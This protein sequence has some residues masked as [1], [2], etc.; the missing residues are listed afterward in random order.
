VTEWRRTHW[1]CAHHLDHAVRLRE[2][3]EEAPAV[4]EP[5]PNRGGLLPSYQ[6]C[7]PVLRPSGRG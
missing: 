1:F 6:E 4:P 3:L 5:I 7:G 2:Q